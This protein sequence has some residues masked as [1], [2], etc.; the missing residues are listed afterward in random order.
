ALDDED[1]LARRMIVR[2]ECGARLE[3]EEERRLSALLVIAQELDGDAGNSQRLPA[4]RFLADHRRLRPFGH[5]VIRRPAAR[6]R[7]WSRAARTRGSAS[8]RPCDSSPR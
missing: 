7:S 6:I 3:S 4:A 8:R 2:R 5:G 1:L